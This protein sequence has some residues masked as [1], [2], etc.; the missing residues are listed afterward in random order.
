[1]VRAIELAVY[2]GIIDHGENIGFL[3]LRT[4]MNDLE[5]GSV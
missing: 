3:A 2:L 5:Q 1:M 4:G